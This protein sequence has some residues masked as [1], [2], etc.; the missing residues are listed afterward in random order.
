MKR[1]GSMSNDQRPSHFRGYRAAAPLKRLVRQLGTSTKSTFPRL[2]SRGPIEARYPGIA[3]SRRDRAFPRLQSRGPIEA[4]WIADVRSSA[5]T[6]PRLQSRGPIEARI[7]S[8]SSDVDAQFPR[9][10]SRGP[11][12]AG[13]GYRRRDRRRQHF[14]GYRAAAPLKH[15]RRANAPVDAASF[16]RLQS[17]GPIEA[18]AA[19]T[20]TGRYFRGYRAAAPLKHAAQAIDALAVQPISA[21]TEPRPH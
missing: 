11:I 17:R 13:S 8:I 18:P 20:S 4:D 16:P 3:A 14:R 9:L 21:A 6:F 10:Q 19:I 5:S 12:E 15:G 2:Q 1:R 7:D